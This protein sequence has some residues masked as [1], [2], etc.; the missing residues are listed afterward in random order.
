MANRITA[1]AIDCADPEP[2][3]GFWIQV[4]GWQVNE[5]AEGIVSIGGGPFRTACIST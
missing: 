1:V 4:L 2:L 5:R 3:A